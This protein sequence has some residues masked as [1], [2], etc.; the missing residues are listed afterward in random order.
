[1]AGLIGAKLAQG[2]S[3]FEATSQAVF[4]HGQAAD[5]WPTQ[6]ALTASRL[7]SRLH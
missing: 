5:A 2:L 6:R 3:A 7:A 1:L 4:K